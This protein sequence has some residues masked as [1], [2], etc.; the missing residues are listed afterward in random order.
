MPMAKI[1]IA[2]S[3]G[4]DS[5]VAAA[6]LQREGHELLGFTMRLGSANA[7][8]EATKACCGLSELHDA[9]RV[10]DVLGIPHYV[11]NHAE[12]FWQDVVEDFLDEYAAGRTPNPCIRCNQHIKFDLFLAQ[13]RALGCEAIA[14]GHYARLERGADG[15]SRLRRGVDAAKDQSY[16]LHTLTQEQ[17][18]ATRL[19]LG[20]LTKPEV[21]ALAAEFSLPTATKHESQDICFVSGDY[22]EFVA[23]H[24]PDA[25]RPGPIVDAGGRPLGTHRGLVWY[26]IGQRKGLGLAGPEAWFVTEIDAPSNTLVVGRAEQADRRRF[27]VRL[28]G[29]PVVHMPPP[30]PSPQAGR[31]PDDRPPGALYGLVQVRYR[32]KAIPC[33]I[34]PADGD[35]V[36]VTLTEPLRGIAPG[37]SAVVYD[38][39][40]Y[41][42][43]GGIIECV[44]PEA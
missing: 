36:A 17:M 39:Q 16:V 1:A 11:V 32:M 38:E 3:G 28:Q 33:Q 24:R 18:A 26:T 31:E 12:A 9:R 40:G 5:S 37:Q 25:A 34:A 19:P 22:A 42:V 20:G 29:E 7:G 2:M 21:R 14:T 30:Q 6:L 43:L 13:A 41:V 35:A 44:L 4:V 15:V 27:L 8:W 10:A 23:A